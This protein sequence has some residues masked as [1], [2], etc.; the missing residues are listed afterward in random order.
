MERVPPEP[1]DPLESADILA[2][3]R[4]PARSIST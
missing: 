4:K 1:P 3:K 2:R